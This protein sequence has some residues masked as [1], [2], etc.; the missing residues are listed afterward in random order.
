[1]KVLVLFHQV[2]KKMILILIVKNLID[3]KNIKEALTTHIKSLFQ[4]QEG[5]CSKIIEVS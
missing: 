2:V 1:M 5:G 3:N 4:L